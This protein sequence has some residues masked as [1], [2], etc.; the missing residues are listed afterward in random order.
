MS[1]L[2][3]LSLLIWKILNIEILLKI[4]FVISIIA[5]FG[6]IFLFV[7]NFMR[8]GNVSGNP[9]YRQVTLTR[10]L[11]LS[12][13]FFIDCILVSNIFYGMKLIDISNHLLFYKVFV[14]ILIFV[15]TPLFMY[16]FYIIGCCFDIFIDFVREQINKLKKSIEKDISIYIKKVLNDYFNLEIFTENMKLRNFKNEEVSY[17]KKDF[18][19]FLKEIN[20]SQNELL[21]ERALFLL[22][23]YGGD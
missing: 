14:P 12:I 19:N 20:F 2:C 5:F 3:I 11:Y 9:Y 4:S 15:L 13:S 10:L 7:F 1:L 8:L 21:K 6:D 18:Y 16:L 22:T 23:K 17:R